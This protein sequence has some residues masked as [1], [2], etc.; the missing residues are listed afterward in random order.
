[1]WA[2]VHPLRSRLAAAGPLITHVL[3]LQKSAPAS[4]KDEAERDSCPVEYVLVRVNNSTREPIFIAHSPT[5]VSRQCNP[6]VSPGPIPSIPAGIKPLSQCHH[7][8]TR[9]N[10][11]DFH[12]VELLLLPLH[13]PYSTATLPSAC[14]LAQVPFRGF[15]SRLYLTSSCF[16]YPYLRYWTTCRH[17]QSQA[18]PLSFSSIAFQ[19]YRIPAASIPP[20]PE[21]PTDPF[22]VFP[23]LSRSRGLIDRFAL[24]A[25]YHFSVC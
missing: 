9:P 5:R 13:L 7:G 17:L 25:T 16:N 2:E 4:G 22:C 20:T 18:R 10:P 14:L 3:H 11:A 1:M 19:R 12:S 23:P 15:H 8:P 21:S 24:T 6:T